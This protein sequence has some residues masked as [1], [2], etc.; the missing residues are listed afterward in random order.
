MVKLLHISD[1]H[2]TPAAEVSNAVLR[3]ALGSDLATLS[4]SI[5]LI[6]VSGDIIQG[7]KTGSAD[8]LTRQYAEATA[9]LDQLAQDLV[10]GDRNKVVIVPGNHDVDWS[11][12]K[13]SM[14]VVTA[15][16]D[17]KKSLLKELFA[18]RSALRWSWSDFEFYRVTSTA[19]YQQRFSAFCRFYDEFY[20]GAHTYPLDPSEHFGIFDYPDLNV[21]VLGLNSCHDNDHCNYAGRINPDCIANAGR[22]LREVRYANRTRIAVWHHNTKGAPQ[23]TAYMDPRIL[24]NLIDLRF[25]VGL[26]GHQHR[27]DIVDEYVSMTRRQRMTLIS[28]GS[29]CA[30]ADEMPTGERRS[31]NLIS[32]AANGTRCSVR[33]RRE[34]TDDPLAPLF[35]PHIPRGYATEEVEFEREMFPEVPTMKAALYDAEKHIAAREFEQAHALLK[36]LDS[37]DPMVRRLLLECLTELRLSGELIKAF[38]PPKNAI[39]VLTVLPV[40]WD[41]RETD[42]LATLLA[43]PIVRDSAAPA[44]RE[45]NKKYTALLQAKSARKA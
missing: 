9:F 28:A 12:S 24:A 38:Y 42:K 2:R 15:S 26:H 21:T 44:V 8:E 19:Q 4:L 35:G 41:E 17:Q 43:D 30:G 1:L 40:L 34:V 6:I 25:A 7:S 36:A 14:T 33:V 5:D 27:T 11:A 32:L 13:A 18:T 37:A 45:L 3:H 20:R 39:E 29:L 23:D 16:G 31:Y 22:V 10:G